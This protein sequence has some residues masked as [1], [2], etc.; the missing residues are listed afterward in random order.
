[1]RAKTVLIKKL[2][3]E[4]MKRFKVSVILNNIHFHSPLMYESTMR[5]VVEDLNARKIDHYVSI[6]S[7]ELFLTNKF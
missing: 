1:M 6:K 4:I 2:T 5:A 3:S 7:T